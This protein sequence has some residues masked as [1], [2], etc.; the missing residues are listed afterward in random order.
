MR[1]FVLFDSVAEEFRRLALLQC[2]DGDGGIQRRGRMFVDDQNTESTS[3]YFFA[4]LMAGINYTNKDFNMILSTGVKNIFNKGYV[5]FI[6]INA[7]PEFPQNQRRY[8]EPG[9]PRNYYVTLNM[10]Y[11]F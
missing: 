2:G 4:N 7:N 8:F 10:S 9:E 6:N 3:P 5:G 11:K 1:R